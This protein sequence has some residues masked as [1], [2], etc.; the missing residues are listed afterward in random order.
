MRAWVPADLD[1]PDRIAFGLTA[2]QLALLGPY[3][4]VTG[5][6]LLLLLDRLPLPASLVVAAALA[7]IGWG[8][9]TA[10]LD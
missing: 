6:A 2:R 4:V 3:A 7:G 10:T 8:I 5:G 9:A 1:R